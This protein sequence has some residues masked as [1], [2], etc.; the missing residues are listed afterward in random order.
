MRWLFLAA[1]VIAVVP[2]G[3]VEQVNYF[4]N[5]ITFGLLFVVAAFLPVENART[6]STLVGVMI[7]CVVF[8]AYIVFQAWPMVDHPFANPAWQDVISEGITDRG[9]I[10]VAPGETFASVPALVIP[11][12][13]FATGLILHQSDRAA[14]QFWVRIALFAGILAFVALIRHELF[15]DAELFG[16]RTRGDQVLTGNFFNRNIAASFHVLSAF[17]LLGV[18]LMQV[19]QMRWDTVK[20]RFGK[21]DYFDEPKYVLFGLGTLLGFATLVALFLT[22][23]RGGVGFGLLALVGSGIAIL[24][25]DRT[26]HMS[27]IL[28]VLTLGGLATL[29]VLAFIILG[30]RTIIR[31]EE[32]GVDENRVCV[33]ESTLAGIADFP[34]LGTGFGAF[35]EVFP[36]YRKLECG[37]DGVWVYAHNSWLEG[38]FG[39]GLPFAFLVLVCLFWLGRELLYGYRARRRFRFIPILIFGIVGYM[40]LHSTLDFPIQIP[41]IAILFAALLSAG[42]AIS[43]SR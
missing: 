16:T 7:I 31:V 15:R 43:T 5:G 39:M 3:S 18:C 8:G 41:G 29:L 23:S 11:F 27:R 24:L 35:R 2:N 14:R 34:L 21:F 42:V 19:K 30:G 20:I 4:L 38:Y 28:K 12:I 40:S 25:T 26:A 1:I 6:R 36:I 13:V 37:I 33:A 32:G 10:S 17:A 22:Q 9:A